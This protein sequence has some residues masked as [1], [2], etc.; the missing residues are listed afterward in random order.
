MEELNCPFSQAT[1]EYQD[2][3]KSRGIVIV[4]AGGA[5]A[6]LSP[7]EQKPVSDAF[8][9][10]GFSTAILNY[11]VG[12][13]LGTLPMQEASWAIQSLRDKKPGMK[14]ILLGFSAGAHLAASVAVHQGDL[15]LA[16]P[17]SLILCY[18]VITAG[19]FGHEESI[20]R[21]GPERK[22][23]YNSLEKWVDYNTPPTFL[24]HT[25]QD[26][27]VPVENSLLFAQAL[28]KEKVPFELHI[29]PFGV[30]GL[31]LATEEV[32]EAAKSRF[33]DPHVASWFELCIQWLERI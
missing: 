22:K 10:K 28:A 3:D 17:D 32:E 6:W 16:R 21:L 14:V 25:A 8:L 5:Y 20:R 24:W 13:D 27:E 18:P 26:P 19:E 33:R 31:S 15:G 12:E 29:Y 1:V 30:H 11:T 23:E 4:C 2:N 7:R 9:A